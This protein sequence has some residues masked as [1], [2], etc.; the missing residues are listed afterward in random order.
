MQTFV[1]FKYIIK[2]VLLKTYYNF[3]VKNRES[4]RIIN[5]TITKQTN[6]QTKCWCN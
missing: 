2:F 6:E 1:M 4:E 3:S 5:N